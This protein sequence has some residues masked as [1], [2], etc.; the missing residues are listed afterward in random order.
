MYDE[1]EHE[2]QVLIRFRGQLVV[3]HVNDC[4]IEYMMPHVIDRK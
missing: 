2:R 4:T 1:M 3:S